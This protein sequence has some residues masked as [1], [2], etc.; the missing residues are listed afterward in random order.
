MNVK[1]ERIWALAF[2]RQASRIETLEES[3][4]RAAHGYLLTEKKLIDLGLVADSEDG[5]AD[6]SLFFH[7]GDLVANRKEKR[8]PG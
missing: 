5:A 4:V 7:R 2:A 8:Q 1:M 6:L 3:V